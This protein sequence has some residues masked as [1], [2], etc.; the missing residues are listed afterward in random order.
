[1][2]EYTETK[3]MFF[4]STDLKA[5]IRQ[6]AREANTNSSAFIR[7][8]LESARRRDLNRKEKPHDNR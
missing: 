1:M 5:W 8:T 7:M 4:L 2:S 6:A 3:M